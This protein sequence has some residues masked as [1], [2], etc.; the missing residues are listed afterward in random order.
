[1]QIKCFGIV[2]YRH[3]FTGPGMG[4]T[5]IS[6]HIPYRIIP[7][8]VPSPAA[9][10]T[11]KTTIVDFVTFRAKLLNPDKVRYVFFGRVGIPLLLCGPKIIKYI[12]YIVS[13][14]RQ[15]ELKCS[16][17]T[18]M[19]YITILATDFTIALITFMVSVR[20]DGFTR[21]TISPAFKNGFLIE[22]LCL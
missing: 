5:K 3:N 9:S 10:I 20:H 14:S 22:V 4:F 15:D 11:I 19:P 17:I 12:Q 1:M 16:H 8:Q 13:V 6:Q 7:K 2:S 21:S 18:E